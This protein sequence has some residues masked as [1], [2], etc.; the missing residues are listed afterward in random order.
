MLSPVAP[1]ST[2]VSVSARSTTVS[3]CPPPGPSAATTVEPRT[4]TSSAPAPSTPKM[5]RDMVAP[6]FGHPAGERDGPAWAPG[7][8]QVWPAQRG[9]AYGWLR[10]GAGRT[11]WALTDLPPRRE[12]RFS[13]RSDEH[14]SDHRGGRSFVS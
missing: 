10:T 1:R 11:L 2:T 6:P 5:R 9:P 12:G 13:A 14:L 8:L 7:K 3:R 4:I